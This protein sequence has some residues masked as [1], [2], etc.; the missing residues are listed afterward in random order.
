MKKKYSSAARIIIIGLLLVLFGQ[1]IRAQSFNYNSKFYRNSQYWADIDTT[2]FQTGDVVACIT[3]N[4]DFKGL[5]TKIGTASRFTHVAMIW[6][7]PA[8]NSLWLMHSTPNDK[9]LIAYGEQTPRSGIILTPMREV[10]ASGHYKM[11]IVYPLQQVARQLINA[12]LL[13]IYNQYKHIPFESH[14]MQFILAGADVEIFGHD[15]LQ[16]KTDK[17]ELFCSEYLAY[18]L[19]LL[20]LIELE[21]QKMAAEYS[22]KEIVQLSL[23]DEKRI[24]KI[25][26]SK[27]PIAPPIDENNDNSVVQ[28]Y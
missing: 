13:D 21:N 15:M 4:K 2:Q 23:F 8:D 25:R 27:L 20:G 6:R 10:I 1:N 3:P 14:V 5:L 16:N 9:H 7:N 12:Q 24:V 28:R 17:S 26:Y 11:V 22:P 18:A 19:Q